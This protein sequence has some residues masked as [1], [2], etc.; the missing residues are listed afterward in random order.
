MKEN[1]NTRIA[2]MRHWMEEHSTEAIVL[3]T[4]D[5]HN[6]EYVA[7]HWQTRQW[8]TGFTGSAG[9]ALVTPT[10]AFLWTDSRYWLQA[11][12]QLAGTPFRL[13]REGKDESLASWLETHTIG[14]IGFLEDMMVPSLFAEV[15]TKKTRERATALPANTFD[16][17]WPERPSLPFSKAEIMPDSL[18]GESAQDKIDRIIK[19]LK[20]NG[21]TELFMSELSEIAWTLNLRADDIPYNPF[22]ISFLLLRSGGEHQLFV[23]RQQLESEVKDYLAALHISLSPYEEGLAMQQQRMRDEEEESPVALFRA[24]KNEV[25]LD[26][27]REAHRRDGVAMVSFLRKLHEARGK[28]WTELTVDRELSA[29]RAEQPGFRGLSF[30]TIAA[31]GPHGAIVHYEATEETSVPL[32]DHGFLLLDSGAHYDCG[33]TDITRTIALGPLTDEERRVYTLVLRGHLQLQNLRFPEGTTGLQLDTAARAAM[34]REGYDFGHGTGHGVGHR[35]GVHEG[36]LQIRKNVRACTLLN[37][38]A[39]QVITDE[40]GIYVTGRFGVRI[41]N[42]LVC[43]ESGETDYGRFLC[44]EPLTLCPYDK[45]AIMP[46]MLSNEERLWLNSYHMRVRT[47][48]SPMLDDPADQAWLCQATEPI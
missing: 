25:E 18:A 5:P 7:A 34:W 36:P 6:S 29:L 12:E 19:W 21:R 1:I 27:F 2:A 8:F 22:L 41:E 23:H 32:A 11:E 4:M 15:F 35:L 30:E 10:E 33:T 42:M 45:H 40:P 48:L 37:I 47:I 44:F 17:L 28:G 26:G 38:R 16:Y 13:M 24:T 9:T 3:P 39:R 14:R 31:C 43:K 46:D 20:A